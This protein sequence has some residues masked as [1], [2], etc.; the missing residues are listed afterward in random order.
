MGQ[1]VVYGR[2]K[3][4]KA[5][6]KLLAKNNLP[7]CTFDDSTG[8][9]GN[10]SAFCKSDTVLLSPGVRP[11][12]FGYVQ[13]KK[14]GAKVVGE[15]QYSFEQCPSK[16]VSVTGTNGKTTTCQLIHHILTSCGVSSKLLGNGGVPF[17]S[18]V[19]NCTEQDVVVLESSSFQ[20]AN[21]TSFSPYISLFTSL[22]VD[23][24]DYHPTYGDYVKSKLNNFVHQ[25]KNCYAIFNAD[26]KEVLKL[27]EKSK[28]FTLFYSVDNVF[29]NC[30]YKDLHVVVNL[31]GKLNQVFCPQ[32]GEMPRHNLSNVLGAI[33][34]STLLGVDVA[35]AVQSATTYKFLPHRLQLVL[36][37]NGVC[38]VDDS[39]A[40]NVH[41]TLSAI[42]AY[43]HQNVALILGGS[44]K[45]MQFDSLFSPQKRN[46]VYYC[47][48]GQTA[49]AIK[50]CAQKYNVCVELCCDMQQAVAKCYH[51]IKNIGGVVLLSNACASFDMYDD[52]QHRGCHFQQV[53]KETMLD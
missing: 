51:A 44:D 21:A 32:L 53:V 49:S 35:T 16:C 4:G 22:A 15:L 11:S 3:T 48:I 28:C 45:G 19:E 1:Y 25:R 41:A 17:C 37:K 40:T 14:C 33:L 29:A 38:F 34:A 23:H 13:C 9:D 36:Q 5:L 42:D 8:F 7:F 12:A 31:F 2:G 24:L 26:D 52:Y 27:S 18:Q 47:A 10:K 43:R 50:Q 30:Y 39:K 6:C 46:V 20:L